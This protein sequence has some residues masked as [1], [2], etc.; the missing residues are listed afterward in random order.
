MRVWNGSAE[1]EHEA[2]T[3]DDE[4]HHSLAKLRD[5][6]VHAYGK[7]ASAAQLYAA[8]LEAQQEEAYFA[9]GRQKFLRMSERKRRDVVRKRLGDVRK[10]GEKWTV[11]SSG[12]AAVTRGV[13]G[14]SVPQSVAARS[15]ASST[16]S[17]A[18][19]AAAA[20]KEQGHN[21][22]VFA[23]R[24][25]LGFTNSAAM[26]PG[27]GHSTPSRPTRPASPPIPIAPLV[28]ADLQ[29]SLEWLQRAAEG[30]DLNP[31]GQ[32]GARSPAWLHRLIRQHA[33]RARISSKHDL[34]DIVDKF[35]QCVEAGHDRPG[36]APANTTTLHG[37]AW[38]MLASDVIAVLTTLVRGSPPVRACAVPPKKHAGSKKPGGKSQSLAAAATPR[39]VYNARDPSPP[40]MTEEEQ[41]EYEL[42]CAEVKKAVATGQIGDFDVDLDSDSDIVTQQQAISAQVEAEFGERLRHLQ[43]VCSGCTAG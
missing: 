35:I 41:C 1:A 21:S 5:R 2:K 13:V 3:D 12:A 28:L 30:V 29:F 39:P 16:R 17:A 43:Q 34:I 31:S 23:P 19:A 15:F 33:S 6:R 7:K 42:L 22:A 25:G 24:F 40:P 9:T 20:K 10:K 11:A 4:W 37:R 36:D 26:R 8:S 27:D 14:A 18:T 32:K 38:C